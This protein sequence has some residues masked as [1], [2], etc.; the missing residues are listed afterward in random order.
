MKTHTPKPVIAPKI[1]RTVTPRKIKGTGRPSYMRRLADK[2]PRSSV[3]QV[4][5][6]GQSL[7][8]K[9]LSHQHKVFTTKIR[10]A[11]WGIAISGG[12][13]LGVAWYTGNMDTLIET[14]PDGAVK[15]FLQFVY[16]YRTWIIL[17]ILML[18]AYFVWKYIRAKRV[19]MN[20]TVV[21]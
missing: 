6:K 1:T 12:L 16:E 17:T 18:T 15:D 9:Q 2:Y 11:G 20:K 21:V 19:L 14:L 10:M 8:P 5:G 13:V 7:T 3:A 4:F